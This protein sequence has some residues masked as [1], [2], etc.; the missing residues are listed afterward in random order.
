MK[1]FRARVKTAVLP[2][3]I[4]IGRF[5]FMTMSFLF[6]AFLLWTVSFIGQQSH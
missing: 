6:L 5:I 4:E 3:S 1:R 2:R